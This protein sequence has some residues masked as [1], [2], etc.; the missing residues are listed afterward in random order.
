MIVVIKQVLRVIMP[1]V[2]EDDGYQLQINSYY[3]SKYSYYCVVMYSECECELLYLTALRYHGN[4][5]SDSAPQPFLCYHSNS[6][7]V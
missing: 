5:D 2:S 3:I 6:D 4:S 1:S 7:S